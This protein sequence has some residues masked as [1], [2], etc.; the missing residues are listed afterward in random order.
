MS[1]DSFCPE[2]GAKLD[3]DNR[4]CDSCGYKLANSSA[5]SSDKHLVGVIVENLRSQSRI[6]YKQI[7][8]LSQNADIAD[9]IVA[10]LENTGN[11]KVKKVDNEFFLLKISPEESIPNQDEQDEDFDIPSEYLSR[12]Q[13]LLELGPISVSSIPDMMNINNEQTEQ[14]VGFLHNSGN[15]QIHTRPSGVIIYKRQ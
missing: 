8:T 1:Y 10:Q 12:L 7:V 13:D 9:R 3:I 4:Y 5:I 6:P 11:Y 15:Y 14:L 2:C